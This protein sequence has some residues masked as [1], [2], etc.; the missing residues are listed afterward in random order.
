MKKSILFLIIIFFSISIGCVK[1][2]AE[3]VSAEFYTDLSDNTVAVGEEFTVYFDKTEGDFVTYFTGDSEETTYDPDDYTVKGDPVNEQPSVTVSYSD[4]GTK[5]FTVVASSVGNWADEYK[6]DVK[7]MTI[8][9][10]E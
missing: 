8:E 5:V 3:S 10:V 9:V 7:S 2:P 1:E 6:R 4:A